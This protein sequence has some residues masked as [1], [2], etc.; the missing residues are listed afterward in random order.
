MGI[1]RGLWTEDLQMKL[2]A[3]NGSVQNLQLPSEIKELY[4]TVWEI[5]QRTVLDMAAARGAYIDQSQSLNIHM[6]D[7]T[8]GKLSSMHFHGWSIG[9]KTGMYYLRTKA[10]V[11]AIKFTVDVDSVKHASSN[12]SI[13][14]GSPKAET[15]EKRAIQALKADEP[16]YSCVGCSA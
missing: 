1:E 9:L 16:K 8:T 10:A 15:S 7:A 5:K 4:K 13:D 6:T 12:T 11:D 2:I 14:S 3:H